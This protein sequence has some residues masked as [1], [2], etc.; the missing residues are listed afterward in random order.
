MVVYIKF[1]DFTRK[2]RENGSASQ[3]HCGTHTTIAMRMTVDIIKSTQFCMEEDLS[4]FIS[5]N[6]MWQK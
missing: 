1:M 2:V 5:V 4:V 6:F 3:N